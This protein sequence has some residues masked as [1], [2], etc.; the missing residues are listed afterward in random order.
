MWGPAIVWAVVLFLLSAWPNPTGPSWLHVSDKVVHFVLFAVLGAALA[1]G[2]QWSG[3]TVPHG[4]VIGVGMLYGAM[5]EWYQALV[6]NRVPSLGDWYA[7]IAGLLFGYFVITFLAKRVGPLSSA[8]S[9][10][11]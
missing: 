11:E 1:V 4:L 7:D 6:P 9:R 2:R 5:N 10:A 8:L 3:G